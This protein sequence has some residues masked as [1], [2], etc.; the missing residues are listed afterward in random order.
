MP[1]SRDTHTLA[2]QHQDLLRQL[3]E[4]GDLRP[5]SLVAD[6]HNCGKPD[7]RCAAE[8]DQRHGPRW[9]LTHKV[10]G[11]TRTRRIPASEFETTRAQ[12]AECQRLRRLV[13]ELV[14]VGEELCQA[15]LETDGRGVREAGEESKK[16][17]RGGL[18]G[19]NPSRDR[20]VRRPG[21]S[22]QPGLRGSRG[23][24]EAARDGGDG[25]GSSGTVRPR[26]VG[27]QG[28]RLPCA[29]GSARW[30][31]PASRPP[32]CMRNASKESIVGNGPS[33]KGVEPDRKHHLQGGEG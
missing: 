31:T 26:P 12:V 8:A 21:R 9:L 33:A 16:S 27:V 32:A 18:P 24:P 10:G 1:A 3:A 23:G 11:K 13:V 20:S 28:A 14:E 30:K 2:A 29:C 17:L 6:S 19:R 7:C 15:R 5:S 25:P 4:I 22:G